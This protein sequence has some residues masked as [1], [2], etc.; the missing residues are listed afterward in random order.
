MSDGGTLPSGTGRP[1]TGATASITAP[2]SVAVGAVRHCGELPAPR[3][4]VHW[5]AGQGRQWLTPRSLSPA[6]AV[7][8]RSRSYFREIPRGCDVMERGERQL[9]PARPGS[10]TPSF[11]WVHRDWS[12]RDL[13]TAP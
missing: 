1:A 7:R 12:C 13:S 9:S 10:L 4:V 11:G 5:A 3:G 6:G 8:L 2:Q